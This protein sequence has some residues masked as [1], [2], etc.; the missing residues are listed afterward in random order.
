MVMYAKLAETL[1]ERRRLFQLRHRVFAEECGYLKPSPDGLLSDAF[2][3]LD[4]SA[5]SIAL[6]DGEIV[7]SVRVT[8]ASR[9]AEGRYESLPSDQ[10]F[11]FSPYLPRSASRIACGSMFVADS[12]RRGSSA[13]I[14]ISQLAHAWLIERGATHCVAVAS[15]LAKG[16]L[17]A[18]GYRLVAPEYVDHHKKL[19]CVPLLVDLRNPAVLAPVL[20]RPRT[21]DAPMATP[22]APRASRV[23]LEEPVA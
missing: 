20:R 14:N 8:F 9:T 12:S 13:A 18:F 4:R 19:V 6:C 11:D 21:H 7:A 22:P 16:L 5:N 10:Y 15:P 3:S 17:M 2:D 23:L 1:E